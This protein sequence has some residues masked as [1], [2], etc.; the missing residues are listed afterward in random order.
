MVLYHHWSTCTESLSPII[1]YSH[2]HVPPLFCVTYGVYFDLYQLRKMCNAALCMHLFLFYLN[3]MFFVVPILFL[4]Y[5]YSVL[6]LC[7]KDT[8]GLCINLAHWSQFLHRIYQGYCFQF[9]ITPW[10]WN[11]APDTHPLVDLGG[12]IS[13][14]HTHECVC[15]VIGS[16]ILASVYTHL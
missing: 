12:T 11:E 9:L 10:N 2:S 6:M 5:V 3:A 15:W 7:I 8:S 1:P 4:N 16:R 14:F 13:R